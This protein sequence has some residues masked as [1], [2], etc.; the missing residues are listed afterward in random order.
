M[1]LLSTIA[2]AE[3]N[4]EEM[5][6]NKEGLQEEDLNEKHFALMLWVG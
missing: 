3:D 2:K 1:H 5:T 6:V 4:T